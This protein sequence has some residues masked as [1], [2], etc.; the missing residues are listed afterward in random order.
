M[1]VPTEML[2]IPWFMMINTFQWTNSYWSL[3]FPNLSTAFGVFLMR[4]FFSGIPNDL[5]DAGRID[6]L[7]EFGIFWK[8]ALPMVKPALS[9]LAIFT[10]LLSWNAFL[11]PVIALDNPNMY[12]LPVGI[13]LFSGEMLNRWDMIRSEGADSE[14]VR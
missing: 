12:T 7:S 1:M 14:R 3:I 5:F 10:F 2:I 6:G 4:Q 9:A 11:W 8:I 13:A